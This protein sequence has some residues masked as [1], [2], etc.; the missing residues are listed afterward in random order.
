MSPARE[1]GDSFEGEQ[2]LNVTSDILMKALS[3]AS[4]ARRILSPS[5]PG[6]YAPGF[7]LP[8]APRTGS[9]DRLYRARRMCK[10][11]LLVSLAFSVIAVLGSHSLS[12]NTTAVSQKQARRLFGLQLSRNATRLLMDV[13]K[14]YGRRVREELVETWDPGYRG[15]AEVI[16]DGTPVIRLNSH[17]GRN[18]TNIVHEL[19]HLKFV[20]EG[21]PKRKWARYVGVSEDINQSLTHDLDSLLLDALVHSRFYPKMRAMGYDPDLWD[22]RDI[23]SMIGISMKDGSHKLVTKEVLIPVHFFKFYLESSDRALVA[24]LERWSVSNNLES[25]LDVAKKLIGIVEQSKI[26]TPQQQLEVYIQC[27]DTLFKGS[28]RFKVASWNSEKLGNI[29][30]QVVTIHIVPPK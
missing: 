23:K 3:P 17:T 24:Q 29:Q 1:A 12:V 11:T 25:A 19:F 18:E 22:R 5:D 2:N 9:R 10:R 28:A 21:F 30:Q 13:E 6:A 15:E 8:S 20:A 16:S 14:Y 27:L 26:D 4:R 7:T